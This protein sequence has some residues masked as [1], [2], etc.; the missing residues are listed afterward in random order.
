[1]SPEQNETEGM[2]AQLKSIDPTVLLEVVRQDQCSLDFQVT[3][4]TVATSVRT[5]CFFSAVRAA[6]G[7]A[8]GPG[9]S[10]SRSC[11]PRL[12]SRTRAT[13]GTGS[14]SC[15]LPRVACSRTYPA[16]SWPRAS[17][18]PR[19]TARVPGYGWNTWSARRLLA[20]R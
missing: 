9:R 8:P 13:Y 11:G 18:G 19:T 10:Y 20:G 12:R 14:E 1:M 2:L 5:C 15:W 3:D 17:T 16:R 7:K 4:W 6:I